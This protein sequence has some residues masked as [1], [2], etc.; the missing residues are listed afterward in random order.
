MWKHQRATSWQQSQFFGNTARAKHITSVDQTW[1]LGLWSVPSVAVHSIGACVSVRN[2]GSLGPTRWVPPGVWGE[3]VP[4]AHNEKSTHSPAQFP[5]HVGLFATAAL[6]LTSSPPVT[7][8]FLR[9]ECSRV[10]CAQWKGS[11][12][13]K[14]QYNDPWDNHGLTLQWKEAIDVGN[15]ARIGEP[16]GS[17]YLINEDVILSKWHLERKKHWN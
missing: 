10:L 4:D 16:Q 13:R 11:W 17:L 8:Q 15:V 5:Y 1:P 7:S 2:G 12:G 3:A 14:R 9:R 6:N